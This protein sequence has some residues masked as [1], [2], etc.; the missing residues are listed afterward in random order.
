M[1]RK[2]PQQKKVKKKLNEAGSTSTSNPDL[3]KQ[4][5]KKLA[6]VLNKQGDLRGWRK[7]IAF[8]YF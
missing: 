3:V 1:P 5:H 4:N 7:K 2:I 6:R 8:I